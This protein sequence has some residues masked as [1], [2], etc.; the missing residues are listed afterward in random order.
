MQ[1]RVTLV[2]FVVYR[3]ILPLVSGYLEAY[4]RADEALDRSCSFEKLTW[5]V[6]DPA[7]ELLRQLIAR[8]SDVYAFSVYMWNSVVSLRIARA[9]AEALPDA[10]IVLGGPQVLNYGHKY[11]SP[12]QPRVV[13]CN[14]GGENMF[15]DFLRGPVLG[16]TGLET[17]PGVSFYADG[18]LASTGK[19]VDVTDVN[20][21]PSPFLTGLF[22]DLKFSSTT[23]ETNRGCPYTCTFC[24]F[25]K[26]DNRKLFKFDVERIKAELAW[27]ADNKLTYLFF[28]DA[29]FGIFPR[30]EELVDYI[31]Q[32]RDQTGYPRIVNFS[33]AKNKPERVSA[34]TERLHGAGV[35][36]SQPVS[37]Q[38]LNDETLTAIRRKNI[39]NEKYAAL[40]QDLGRKGIPT[41]IELIWPLPKESV[42]S[43]EN[44]LN[45]FCRKHADTIS[46][47]PL[48]L[49]NNTE[50]SSERERFG[51]V[52]VDI[53]SDT[54]EVEIVVGTDTVTRQ[55]Y[56]DGVRLIYGAY[57]I[58]NMRSLGRLAHYLDAAHG[59]PYTKLFRA[60]V[61]Y[62]ADQPEFVF[63][64]RMERDLA[65]FRYYYSFTALG[66]LAYELLHVDR[67]S[68]IAHLHAFVGSQP[69]FEDPQAQALFDLDLVHLPYVYANTPMTA[70]EELRPYLSALDLREVEER[71]Y[72]VHV[73]AQLRDFLAG[74]LGVELGVNDALWSVDHFGEQFR[75][76]E[77][78]TLQHKAEYCYG[79]VKRPNAIRPKVSRS[80]SPASPASSFASV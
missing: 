14:G 36:V 19:A 50:M 38:S 30:D 23:Y 57:V 29:N 60:F 18:E 26:G 37:F 77:Q 35:V 49:L 75:H 6:D 76:K 48:C 70:I 56:D 73:P 11:L 72:V 62:A 5:H 54:T 32:L 8:E 47:Y 28:A 45:S 71:R 55:E 34:I 24:F 46:I 17:V 10:H 31:C 64:Q 61:R 4:A 65:S 68:F 51:A 20:T 1:K 15:R 40:Q 22:D 78:R 21:I 16:G 80:P 67:P 2:E 7:D 59:L 25:S 53:P 74:Q 44:G 69:W 43:F 27:L 13:I 58:Y 39:K 9:L 3:G 66:A 42:E 63:T 41:M 79:M 52:T 33:A 12:E